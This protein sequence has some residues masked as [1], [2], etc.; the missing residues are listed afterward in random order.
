MLPQNT[1]NGDAGS[2]RKRV[3]LMIIAFFVLVVAVTIVSLVKQSNKN[4]IDSK[5]FATFSNSK[6]SISYPKSFVKSFD[7]NKLELSGKVRDG[8]VQDA[9]TVQPY[10]GRSTDNSLSSIEKSATTN[11]LNKKVADAENTTINGADALIVTPN[12][13]APISQKKTLYIQDGSTIWQVVAVFA[14]SNSELATNIDSIFQ[15][16]LIKGGS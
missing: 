12:K 3:L 9:L 1:Y 14:S 13:N 8:E 4:R 11:I 5:D 7:G 15:S 2:R 16:F 10:L 6:I